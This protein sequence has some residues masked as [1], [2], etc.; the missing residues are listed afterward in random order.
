MACNEAENANE[1]IGTTGWHRAFLIRL[2]SGRGPLGGC[3]KPFRMPPEAR[4]TLFPMA[5]DIF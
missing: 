5:V 4:Q 1:K 2:M 3:I